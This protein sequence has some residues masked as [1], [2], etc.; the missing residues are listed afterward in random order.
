MQSIATTLFGDNLEEVKLE[1]DDV[2]RLTISFKIN[3]EEKVSS[4]NFVFFKLVQEKY[5]NTKIY[6]KRMLRM[7]IHYFINKDIKALDRDR[8]RIEIDDFINVLK[9]FLYQSNKKSIA[10]N[11]MK[12]YY[13]YLEINTNTRRGDRKYISK[14]FKIDNDVI[15][16]NVKDEYENVSLN[17]TLYSQSNYELNSNIRWV[18]LAKVFVFTSLIFIVIGMGI[19][20]YTKYINR[21]KIDKE[22][23]VDKTLNS[24]KMLNR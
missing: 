13:F 24:I 12:Y 18:M 3:A 7:N 19:L 1:S 16:Y 23:V 2:K 8:Q 21:R 4:G 15:V 5:S 10:H 11:M 17:N 9:D 6:L 22:L 14:T 20:A